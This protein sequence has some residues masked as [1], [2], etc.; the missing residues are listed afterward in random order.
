MTELCGSDKE[1]NIFLRRSFEICSFSLRSSH[2]TLLKT[3]TEEAH[4]TTVSLK[5]IHN[6][7]SFGV[8]VLSGAVVLSVQATSEALESNQNVVI[9]YSG[10]S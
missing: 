5:I 10:I 4:L 6:Q 8:V 3:L 2:S 9:L 1:E 7:N